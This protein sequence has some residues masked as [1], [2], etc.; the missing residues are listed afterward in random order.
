MRAVTFGL[1]GWVLGQ[2]A[3]SPSPRSGRDAA[4]D[5]SLPIALARWTRSGDADSVHA[6]LASPPD[7][8]RRRWL[9]ALA[10]SGVVVG[11]SSRDT[12]PVALAVEPT[13]D[14]AGGMRV[15]A[16][17]PSGTRIVLGDGLGSIDTMSMESAATAAR[18]AVTSGVLTAA[19]AGGGAR[20]AALPTDSLAPRTVL[21]LGRAGWEGKFVIA[22][23]EERGWTVAARLHVA[24]GVDVTQR[25]PTP[26]D[27]AHLAAVIALDTTAARDAAALRAFVRSGGGLILAGEAARAPSLAPLSAGA[28]GDR[29]GAAMLA[30]AANDPRRALGFWPIAPLARGAVVLERNGQ[31]IVAA[32]RRLGAGRVL[33]LGYDDSW[34]WRMSGTGDAP[35]AHRAYW[36]QLVTSAAYRPVV[37]LAPTAGDPSPRAASI[38]LLGPPTPPPTTRVA[39]ESAGP[40]AWWAMV[41]LLALLLGEWASRRLRGA[42]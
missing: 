19:P 38:A 28:V 11:W 35:G 39:A 6:S 1:I 21:V 2:A 25:T 5:R 24:P 26:L 33:Q 34:R 8:L 4:D 30:F 16:A 29:V 3:R 17:A 37:P 12:T 14:P 15:R 18:L 13:G 7:E 9:A 10:R 20:A 41:L 23:L 27:T 36:S 42:A 32:G 31:R 22:A 40:F